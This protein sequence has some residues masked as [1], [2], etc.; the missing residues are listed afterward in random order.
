MEALGKIKETQYDLILMDI[1]MPVMDGKQCTREIRKFDREL[2]IIALTAVTL[3]ESEKEFY[4]IGFDD[5]IPK[6]FK[7]N[8][9]FE[10]IQKAF[11]N[12]QI[13]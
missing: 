13:Y 10:K 2:P 3:D 8:E 7:M 5:I 6:P 9:F 1:H 4:E 12:Y 11:T